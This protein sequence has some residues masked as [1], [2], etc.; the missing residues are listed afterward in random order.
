MAEDFDR[1]FKKAQRLEKQLQRDMRQKMD[2]ER[3][4]KN[5]IRINQ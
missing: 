3:T 2:F 1:D 4:G 5:V